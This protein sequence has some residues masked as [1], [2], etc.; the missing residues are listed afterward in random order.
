M[1]RTPIRALLAV[2]SAAA[3]AA[4]VLMAAGG[5]AHAAAGPGPGFPARY[6][7]PYT[8]VWNSPSALTAARNA[9]GLKYFTLAFVIDGG[10]C[11]ATFNGDTPI[12]D[13]GWTSAINSL[14]ASGGD[15]IASFGGASGTEEALACTSVSALKTQYRRVIDGLNLTRVDFDIEGSSLNNTTAN[16][17]RNAALAD[18]QQQYAA[19][20][21]RLDVQYTL[22]V[23]PTGLASNSISLLDNARS[24]GL[25]VTL[26]NIMSMDY[27]PSMDMGQAAISAAQGLHTQLGRIWTAKSSAELWAMEGNTP[28]VGVNDATNEVFTT[29]DAADLE[30]FAES[31]GIQELSFWSLGR[32]KACGSTGRLSD[33]CSGTRQSPWQ[34]SS[35]FN[36]V[37]GGALAP[38]APPT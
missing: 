26:V 21:R 19:A 15:V 30:N 18:L 9:T 24:H 29:S 35:T 14:R 20:G 6:A 22:P 25:N 1:Q 10:R 11:N 4:G 38:A 36:A 3:L 28:M 34:F 7:A 33:S 5:T 8:E 27:G 13:G 31:H 37:T 2:T 16:D 23:N 32:D 12:T 17:R